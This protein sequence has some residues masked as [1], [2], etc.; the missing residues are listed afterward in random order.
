MN[1]TLT[2]INDISLI[3]PGDNLGEIIA[4][5]TLEQKICPKDGDI[6]ILAQK[7]VSKA[8]GRMVN[9]TS[10]TPSSEAYKYAEITG[11][12]PRFVELVLRESN[13]VVRTAYNTLIVEHKCGFV[14]ANAGIDHSNVKGDWGNDLD[15]VL[16]LPEDSDESARQIRDFLG[17]KF[18]CDLGVLI[19]DSHGRAWRNGT[20]GITIGLSGL[21]GLVDLRGVSDLFGFQLKITQVAAADELAA[22]ASLLMGQASE[23]TPVVFARGFPYALREANLQELIRPKEQDL[24]R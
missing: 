19:I 11:K 4:E 6:F 18:D 12:D 9:L 2:T 10:V 5:K 17:R 22:G 7:I 8:E 16:L 13:N 23:K 21:P 3:K 24:F 14:S 15:W 20:V 1:L